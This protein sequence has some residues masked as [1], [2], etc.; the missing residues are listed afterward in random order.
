MPRPDSLLVAAA[1]GRTPKTT[2]MFSPDGKEPIELLL[3]G[4]PST[5]APQSPTPPPP[6]ALREFGLGVLAVA[7]VRWLLHGE[8]QRGHQLR[9]A[10]VGAQL[11]A[12]GITT[13]AAA[14]KAMRRSGAQKPGSPVARLQLDC[15]GA[16]DDL[17][18]GDS[19]VQR[20][21][22]GVG[23]AMVALTML[24]E[25]RWLLLVARGE[26]RCT[27]DLIGCYGALAH[28]MITAG[29]YTAALICQLMLR[30][31]KHHQQSV[32][33]H[34]GR[35]EQQLLRSVMLLRAAC[36]LHVAEAIPYARSCSS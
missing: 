31:P 34:K 22:W 21:R 29:C 23:G 36:V 27:G 8:Q 4:P 1:Q 12:C 20:C 15:G 16:N 13:A 5:I 7:A 3:D 17:G 18:E 14:L 33:Q 6:P 9:A 25:S 24:S 35:V 28:R 26:G 32:V 19:M 30:L 11:L 2:A 10:L